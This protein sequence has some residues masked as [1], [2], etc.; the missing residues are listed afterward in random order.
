MGMF[1][2]FKKPEKPKKKQQPVDDD[3]ILDEDYDEDEPEVQ[4]ME[5][6]K[7]PIPEGDFALGDFR[8]K[9]LNFINGVTDEIDPRIIVYELEF[10]KKQIIDSL[11][12]EPE[13]DS[14]DAEE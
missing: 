10:L 14:D 2:N 9:L 11:E 1:D 3:E 4:V 6:Q 5:E 12:T 7:Q 13:E 8:E